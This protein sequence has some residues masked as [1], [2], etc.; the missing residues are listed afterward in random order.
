VLRQRSSQLQKYKAAPMP[1]R[2]AVNQKLCKG[3][4][5]HLG[6]TVWKL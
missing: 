4:G 2:T 3:A 1:S 6:L 5:R